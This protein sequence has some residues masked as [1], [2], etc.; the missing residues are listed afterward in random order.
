MENQLCRQKSIDRI[1]SPEQLH[2]YM[3][4]T[5]PKLWMI[6]SA[7]IVLM[8]GLIVLA[9][10]ANME[11]TMKVQIKIY[12]NEDADGKKE[13]AMYAL[14]EQPLEQKDT[15]EIG[16]EVRIAG[17]KGKIDYLFEDTDKITASV[18]FTDDADDLPDGLYDG[19]IVIERR[20]PI[21][22]LLN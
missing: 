14:V 12:H 7:I 2:D 21:S 10:T 18:V 15:L 5:S 19:E 22:F 1:S 11:N 9:S 6:L 8:V 17:R 16:Q 3:R 20:T 4:V 13:E